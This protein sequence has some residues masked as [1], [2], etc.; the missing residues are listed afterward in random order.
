MTALQKFIKFAAIAFGVFL[1]ASVALGILSL[2]A[3]ARDLSEE[4]TFEIQLA[5][6]SVE[7]LDIEL[8]GVDFSLKIG[9]EIKLET[10]NKN[11]KAAF[12]GESLEIEENS[13]W[14]NRTV[15]GK[16]LLTLPDALIPRV[17]LEIGAGKVT[18][19]KL[20]ANFIEF[21]FG[22]GEVAINEL[23]A[24]QSAEIECGAGKFTLSNGEL[25]NL[26]MDLGVG[27]VNIGAKL[28]GTKNEIDCG[29]GELNLA[30]DKKSD[31]KIQISKGLGSITVGGVSYE[32]NAVV[33]DG[34]RK[35]ELNG[36]IGAIKIRFDED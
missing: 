28:T 1:I 22:A 31:Y 21:D 30:L 4:E 36:G 24:H 20:T 17:S 8:D 33:G 3:G 6:T 15:N 25:G 9:E 29:V 12:K 13:S 34:E 10:N 11:V 2:F 23:Y 18:I 16:V 32:N 14:F 26:D 27:E 5:Q 35:I 7:R 19:E